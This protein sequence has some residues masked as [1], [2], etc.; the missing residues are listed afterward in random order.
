MKSISLEKYDSFLEKAEKQ[1]PKSFLLMRH[2]TIIAQG[3]NGVEMA[4]FI[5]REESVSVL[6]FLGNTWDEQNI[7]N[8]ID[9]DIWIKKDNAWMLVNKI[10]HLVDIDEL[11]DIYVIVSVSGNNKGG[12]FDIYIYHN[13][14]IEKII[15]DVCEYKVG[16]DLKVYYILKGPDAYYHHIYKRG[17]SILLL[18]SPNRYSHTQYKREKY[19][20]DYSKKDT[21]AEKH[22]K[23]WFHNSSSQNF[24][25]TE[26]FAKDYADYYYIEESPFPD[27]STVN[28]CA[29]FNTKKKTDIWYMQEYGCE[30]GYAV[31]GVTYDQLIT[32]CDI[33]PSR[34]KVFIEIE[35]LYEYLGEEDTFKEILAHIYD[36]MG[37][38]ID[39]SQVPYIE[40]YM[41][42]SDNQ[43]IIRSTLENVV[44]SYD[45]KKKKK[46]IYDQLI[47]EGILIPNWK[48]EFD[49]YKVVKKKY[50]DCI[51]QYRDP[52]L[53]G[54]SIDVFIP[55]L[56]VGIEYQGLQHYEPVSIFGGE[57]GFERTKER[58]KRKLDICCKNDIKLLYWKYDEPIN[59][60]QLS[61]KMATLNS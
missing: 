49:L 59:A 38:T 36:M 21:D 18:K 44:P 9:Y 30:Y 17:E 51:F 56:K 2:N 10:K 32:V 11:K 15:R 48:T 47:A 39:Y 13:G 24:Y 27:D 31:Y 23:I 46:E 5:D 22:V 58:D 43:A 3:Q 19:H 29:V 8:V 55:S 50:V 20:I 16:Q 28:Y 4:M 12:S 37:K 7:R 26:K 42:D 40:N 35:R 14:F 1:Y 61:K 52:V 53:K 34:E 33:K 41:P 45:L 54:Q 6:R 57:E 60:V 25:I